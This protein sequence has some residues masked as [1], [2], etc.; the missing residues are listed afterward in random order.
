MA[1]SENIQNVGPFDRG[2]RAA[3]GIVMVASLAL[4]P[5]VGHW[6]FG[7][8]PMIGMVLLLS[9]MT[10]FCPLYLLAN[11]DTGSGSA[12]GTGTGAGTDADHGHGMAA[13]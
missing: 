10:G 7:M 4:L 2:L 5:V 3:L 11:I 6:V 8:L 12:P 1:S 13:R 9:G